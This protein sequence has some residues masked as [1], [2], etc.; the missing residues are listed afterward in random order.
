ME[1]LVP[2][3]SARG[4]QAAPLLNDYDEA[5]GE[6]KPIWVTPR[7]QAES[8]YAEKSRQKALARAQKKKQDAYAEKQRRIKESVPEHLQD[9]H[10]LVNG[11]ERYG[12]VFFRASF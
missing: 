7:H 3:D 2:G 10:T 12:Y 6:L 4:V 5:T 8:A 9:Q 1:R 11:E